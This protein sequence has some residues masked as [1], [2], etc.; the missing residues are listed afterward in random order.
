MVSRDARCGSWLRALLAEAPGGPLTCS[1]LGRRELPARS[2]LCR[3]DAGF[4]GSMLSDNGESALPLR[5]EPGTPGK[6]DAAVL[7]KKEDA[8]VSGVSPSKA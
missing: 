1:A 4:G 6:C 8:G 2:E 3:S 7:G 5:E